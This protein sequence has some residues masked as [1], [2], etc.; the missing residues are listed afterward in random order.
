MSSELA[1]V[2]SGYD[3]HVNG[4]HDMGGMHGFGPIVVEPNEP[5]FHAAWEG[6]VRALVFLA[7]GKRVANIDAFRHAIERLD[8]VEYL[9]AG[10]YGRWL[11]ALELL[12]RDWR[13]RGE[14]LDA[15][16]AGTLRRVTTTARF[17]T[18]D[19]VR[20]RN[21]QPV[22]HTRLPGYAR[23]KRGTIARVHAGFVFPDT[24]ASGRGEHPQWVYAVRFDAA[25]LFG[26]GAE[27]NACVHID[28]FESYLDPEPSGV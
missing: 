3:R 9:S 21:L 6:R 1:A 20:T 16:A 8:P 25:E 22:G 23:G 4:I 19:A 28:L 17:A 14:T 26:T 15:G 5:V 7:I 27:P 13:A 18:G 10:Y 24:N 12:V 2:R 11:G